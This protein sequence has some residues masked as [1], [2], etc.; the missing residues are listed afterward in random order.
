MGALLLHASAILAAYVAAASQAGAALL[1]CDIRDLIGKG[2]ARSPI[3]VRYEG[4]G[5]QA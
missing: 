3:D 1:S 5:E 4:D 2:L